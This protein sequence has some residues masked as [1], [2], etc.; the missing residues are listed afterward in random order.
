MLSKKPPSIL[1]GTILIVT[2]FLLPSCMSLDPEPYSD[3]VA[4]ETKAD[5]PQTRQKPALPKPA[6]VNDVAA[7]QGPLK[8]GIQEAIILAM[9][10]N[11]SL[12]VERMNPQISRTFE[13][14]ELSVFDPMLGA[15]VSSRRTL[16]DRLSRA[17]SSTESSTVD[18]V[19]GLVS[20]TKLFP[21]GTSVGLEAGT[22]YTDSSLYSDT[23]TANRLGFTV[24]QA[25][26]QGLDIR[27]NLARVNQARLDTLISHYELRG[28]TEMLLEQV[29]SKFWDYALAQR[30]I[31]I[32]TNSLNLA[33]KQM[34]E[35]E[36]R[37]KIGDLAETELAAAQAEVALRRENLINAGST[38]AKQRLDLLRLLNP[39]RCIDWNR[40]VILEYDTSLP[41][42]NLDNVDQHVRVALTMR[43]DLN[44]ARLHIQQGDLEVV[45]TRNGLLPKMDMFIA[46]GKTGYAD[47]FGRAAN[48]IGGNSYD[49]TWGLS[50]EHPPLNRSARARYARALTGRRQMREALENLSQLVQVDVR[51]AYIE[52][53]SAHE[54]IT[55]TAATRN[56]QEEKLRAET[57]KFR[58]GKSTSLLVGQAQRDFVGSQ[59]AETQAVANYLEALVA[60]YR[61][62]G[63]LLQRRGISL[64]GAAPVAVDMD[65]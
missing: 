5:L 41:D 62:E 43:P 49:V 58:V 36:E 11:Q 17:G 20:L 27:A 10:N 59:I 14:E 25:L 30:Q 1:R 45:R 32:Y 51:S 4:P 31:E 24:T 56:F 48:N 55:A 52:V 28:F 7:P 53:T 63:S 46:F 19:T 23:F 13:Q 65:K 39:S 6:D 9:E 26:L 57:E 22:T 2:A 8:I 35:T 33:D 12:I 34:A 54:Q 40:D 29:E 50:L 3:Y 18:S 38:L 61:L 42:V 15:E 44:Q 64:P 47:T 37:I 60:L 16:A 21:T